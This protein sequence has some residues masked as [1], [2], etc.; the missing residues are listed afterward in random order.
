MNESWNSDPARPRLRLRHYGRVYLCSEGDIMMKKT[1][2]AACAAASLM[3]SAGAGAAATFNF[4]TTGPNELSKSYSQ[5]GVSFTVTGG[6]GVGTPYVT[7]R[8]RGLGVYTDRTVCKW[9]FCTGIFN[10]TDLDL[11]GQP[12]FEYLL[13]TFDLPVW[14]EKVWFGDADDDDEWKII[15]DGDTVASNNSDNPYYFG[16]SEKTSWFAVKAIDLDDSFTVAGL[17]AVV[18]LPAA[19][20]LLLGGIGGLAALRRRKAAA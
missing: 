12:G 10:D 5:N 14:L 17:D 8:E 20:W 6:V 2:L 16:L 3:L 7:E 15:V 18:P 19:G 13:F 11:D 9:G 4:D 1:C